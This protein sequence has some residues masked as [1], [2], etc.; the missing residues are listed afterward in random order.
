MSFDRDLFDWQTYIDRNCVCILFVKRDH[1]SAFMWQELSAF[2]QSK[3][4]RPPGLSWTL[5]TAE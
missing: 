1:A 5:Q 3:Q 4:L 2:T